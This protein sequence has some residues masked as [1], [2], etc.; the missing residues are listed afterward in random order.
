MALFNI[1]LS[2]RHVV[3]VAYFIM[4]VRFC[5]SCH[6]SE[7][8][9]TCWL[10]TSDQLSQMYK[11]RLLWQFFLEITVHCGLSNV[12]EVSTVHDLTLYLL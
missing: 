10:D 7:I 5:E 11:D 12:R 4:E 2:K 1:F 3:Y 8:K 6:G 9:E